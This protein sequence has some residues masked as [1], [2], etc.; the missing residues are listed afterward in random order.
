MA[1]T[2]PRAPLVA[3]ALAPHTRQRLLAAGYATAAD[4]EHL[5][6]EALAAGARAAR[7]ALGLPWWRP[8]TAQRAR[9]T[10]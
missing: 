10:A 8:R 4:L 2:A 5:S 3:L 7:G 9:P 1:S 6:P